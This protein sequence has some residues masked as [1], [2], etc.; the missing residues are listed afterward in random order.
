MSESLTIARPYAETAFQAAR[1][2]DALQAWGD[3]LERLAAI[4]AQ[5]QVADLIGNPAVK[6]A[7]LADLIADVA[8]NLTLEQRNFVH[9]LADNGRLGVLPDVAQLYI[10][11]QHREQGVLDAQVTSAFPLTDAQVNEIRSLLEARHGCRVL[12]RVDVDPDLIGGVSIRIGDAVTDMSVRGK[13]AQLS[14]ALTH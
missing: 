2:Q 4:V 3:A 13:L 9:L 14:A 5:P 1:Q 11:L 12:I 7:Q 10:R 8:Q 6:P